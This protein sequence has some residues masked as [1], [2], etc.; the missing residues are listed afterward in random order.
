V[1]TMQT[2]LVRALCALRPRRLSRRK[3]LD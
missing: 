2:V 3:V 1:V